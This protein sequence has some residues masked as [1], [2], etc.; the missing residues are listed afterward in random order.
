M[1]TTNA[2]IIPMGI[3]GDGVIDDDF[4][5][6][7]D[8]ELDIEDLTDDA[9][10]NLDDSSE[11]KDSSSND[12]KSF[13][14]DVEHRLDDDEK[15]EL[16]EKIVAYDMEIKGFQSELTSLK[17]TAAYYKKQISELESQRLK[18]SVIYN[19]GVVKRTHTAYREPDYEAGVIF[20]KDIVTNEILAEEEMPEDSLFTK[21]NDL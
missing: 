12:E 20:T 1:E 4:F 14:F 13:S 16:A 8:D 7:L 5:D 2:N 19:S 6:E 15:R 10:E 17:N 9:L 3:N 21:K 11:A 18:Q